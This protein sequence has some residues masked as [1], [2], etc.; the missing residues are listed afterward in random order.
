MNWSKVKTILIVFFLC[1]DIFCLFAVMSGGNGKTALTEEEIN[2]TV[3]VLS[4]RK[5]KISPEI[6]IQKRTECAHFEANNAV[7]DYAEFAGMLMENAEKI[8]DTEYGNER[9]K[10]T[11]SGDKFSFE[12]A[13]VPENGNKGSEKDA[14]RLVQGFLNKVLTNAGK[15]DVSAKVTDTGYE[16]TLRS[17]YDGLPLFNSEIKAEVCYGRLKTVSGSW[18]YPADS[19]GRDNSVKSITS[20]LIDCISLLGDAEETEIVSVELGYMVFEENTYHKSAVM[21]PVWQIKTA[22]GR[23]IYIDARNAE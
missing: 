5:I 14:V 17:Q 18:F 12:A 23:V 4:A 6:I 20:A 21:I 11:Y 1:V 7:F 16:V 9:G 2:T 8:S 10:L 13:S 19:A 22:D 15:E 3:E